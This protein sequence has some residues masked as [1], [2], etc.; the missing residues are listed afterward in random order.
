LILRSCGVFDVDVIAQMLRAHVTGFPTA[1]KIQQ[2]V[3]RLFFDQ[4]EAS[5]LGRRKDAF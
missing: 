2:V 4:K 3:V 5:L 1:I